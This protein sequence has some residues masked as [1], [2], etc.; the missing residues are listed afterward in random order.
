MTYVVIQVGC[1]VFGFGETPAAAVAMANEFIDRDAAPLDP[2]TI[3]RYVG[4]APTTEARLY[5]RNETKAVTQYGE[6]H[7]GEMV[8]VTLD[9]AVSMRGYERQLHELG[10]ISRERMLKAGAGFQ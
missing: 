10:I 5:G 1:A 7:H 3:S 2:E 4:G 8:L 9:E 6:M